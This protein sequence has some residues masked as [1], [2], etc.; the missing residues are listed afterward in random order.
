MI[1]T[2]SAFL[3]FDSLKS[4]SLCL[5]LSERFLEGGGASTRDL[6]PFGGGARLCLGETVAKMEL[7]LFTAY[8]LRDFNFIPS[9]GKASLP[10]LRGVASVVLKVKSF[11]VRA[12]PRRGTDS[13]KSVPLT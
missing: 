3:S 5:T 6:I 4:L 13:A 1:V 2:L 8:L 11:T 9:E 7:F 12:R 10:D